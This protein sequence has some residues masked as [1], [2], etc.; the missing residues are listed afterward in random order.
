MVPLR[1]N[2]ELVGR[3]CRRG[4]RVL[5]AEDVESFEPRG[6]LRTTTTAGILESAPELALVEVL[7]VADGQDP[8]TVGGIENDVVTELSSDGQAV[9]D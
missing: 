7:G 3:G 6:A 1:S 2:G 8:N 9:K 4:N 5:G